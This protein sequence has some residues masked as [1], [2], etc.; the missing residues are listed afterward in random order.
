MK[1]GSLYVSLYC[2][3]EPCPIKLVNDVADSA[4]APAITA[5]PL[6]S[7]TP[8][9]CKPAPRLCYTTSHEL[10]CKG[11]A[12]VPAG[13]FTKHELKQLAL[14]SPL[15]PGRGAGIL[16]SKKRLGPTLRANGTFIPEKDI[17]QHES[18]ISRLNYCRNKAKTKSSCSKVYKAESSWY[19]KEDNLE[20]RIPL[21]YKRMLQESCSSENR[22]AIF[23]FHKQVFEFLPFGVRSAHLFMKMHPADTTYAIFAFTLSPASYV[24]TLE[25]K[26]KTTQVTKNEVPYVATFERFQGNERLCSD[27]RL[28][29]FVDG[30]SPSKNE[31][32]GGFK[33]LENSELPMCPIPP[34][35][36][37]N[38]KLTKDDQEGLEIAP[39]VFCYYE[40]WP[41]KEIPVTAKQQ[42][43]AVPSTRR[44]SLGFSRASKS[45][46]LEQGSETSFYSVA[47][48]VGKNIYITVDAVHIKLM[49]FILD[50]WLQ[51]VPLRQI[52]TN[53]SIREKMICKVS[54][55][56]TYT[57]Y[58]AF[59][60]YTQDGLS[61]QRYL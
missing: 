13:I 7:V 45:T 1:P 3:P 11:F 12:K 23:N 41:E 27:P 37:R 33:I 61:S 20:V 24:T 21:A 44:V 5:L 30:L 18:F 38:V 36:S 39:F 26:P 2:G 4:I 35:L 51:V 42:S 48:C 22:K 58:P 10:L 29:K 31:L 28:W 43:D 56:S 17:N 59:K 47:L 9:I 16:P 19:M 55:M 57:T 50:E 8:A 15:V 32:A 54:Q 40:P 60:S 52:E 34:L 53:D 25:E 14:M 49:R 46:P 6:S